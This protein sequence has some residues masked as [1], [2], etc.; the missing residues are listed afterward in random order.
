MARESLLFRTVAQQQTAG[1]IDINGVGNIPA[2]EA[3]GSP[4]IALT[5][6][7]T[8]IGTLEVFGSPQIG[9]TVVSSG[10]VSEEAFGSSQLTLDISVEGIPTVEAFGKP[11]VELPSEAI[12]IEV[13][14]IE[15]EEAF[16][17]PIV[18]LVKKEEIGFHGGTIYQEEYE[19]PRKI[20]SLSVKFEDT[21]VTKRYYADRK[22][23]DVTAKFLKRKDK[24]E[25]LVKIVA[26]L[27][28]NYEYNKVA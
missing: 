8:G 1:A 13:A 28:D 12:T 23:G 4:S 14:G 17:Q 21:S 20:I 2:A 26:K 25:S 10:I 3:F 22:R 15:S 5:I 19:E 16:G 27:V 24:E 18:S 11:T 7:E 9:L 6:A